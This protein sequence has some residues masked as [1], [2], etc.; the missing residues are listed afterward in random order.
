M[1]DS[2]WARP[3]GTGALVYSGFVRLQTSTDEENQSENGNLR[4]GC[5][6]SFFLGF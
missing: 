4:N 5:K 1:E 3:G 6:R 2:T